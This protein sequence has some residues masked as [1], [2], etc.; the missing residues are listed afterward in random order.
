[1]GTRALRAWTLLAGLLAGATAVHA[2]TDAG[3]A[4][5]VRGV[6]TAQGKD[7]G[8]RIINTGAP[9]RAGD[10][11]RTARNSYAVLRL[12]DD[13]KI[14]LRPDTVFEIEDFNKEAGTGSVLLRL[15]KGGMRAIT[16]LV[17]KRNPKAF[18]LRSPTATI[19]IRGTDFEAR[20]CGDDCKKGAAGVRKAKKAQPRV[21]GRV[22]FKSGTV[23]ATGRDGND[24]D[25]ALGAS[26][27]EGDVLKTAAKSVAVVVFRD[28]SRVTMRANSTLQVDK[29]SY[30]A[31]EPEKGSVAMRFARGGV[32]VV[33][34]LI[35]G[36][37][38]LSRTR[39]TMLWASFS[40]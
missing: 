28:K 30:D 26:L 34:G 18:R 2:A 23:T 32:R 15:F 22:A 19:G 33:S 37:S 25:L 39:S 16:G 3:T 10:V 20:L 4:T 40:R 38:A 9:L 21:I 14:T 8:A 29:Y 24:R 36:V 12:A 7:G 11:L 1:M 27:L 5:F 31:D 17:A 13:S 6:A 35:A